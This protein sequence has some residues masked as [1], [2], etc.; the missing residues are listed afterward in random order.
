MSEV[1][2]NKQKKRF[3]LSLDGATAL[4]DYIESGDIVSMTHT[5][6]PSAFEGKGVGSKLVKGALEIVK[7]DGKRVEPACPFIAGYIERHPE[8]ADLVAEF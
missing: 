7:R 1:I 2:D 3:E 5:E 4:I 6:V 8:F